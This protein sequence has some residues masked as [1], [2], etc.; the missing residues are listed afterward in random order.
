MWNRV[1]CVQHVFILGYRDVNMFFTGFCMFSFYTIIPTLMLN[2][3]FF[4]FF[5]WILRM[6]AK[7]M[8]LQKVLARC[9]SPEN[10]L[11]QSNWSNLLQNSGFLSQGFLIFIVLACPLIEWQCR[12]EYSVGEGNMVFGSSSTTLAIWWVKSHTRSLENLKNF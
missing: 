9:F 12:A 4:F 6:W 11:C 2:V 1:L 7:Y 5:N 10:S 3:S 8:V